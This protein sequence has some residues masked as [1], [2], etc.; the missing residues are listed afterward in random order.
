MQGIYLIGQDRRE[1]CGRIGIPRLYS[2]FSICLDSPPSMTAAPT[3]DLSV[4]NDSRVCQ[5]AGEA[6]KVRSSIIAVPISPFGAAFINLR[7]EDPIGRSP[8]SLAAPKKS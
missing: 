4:I 8:S 1:H 7:R 5:Y 6:A 2:A 3:N